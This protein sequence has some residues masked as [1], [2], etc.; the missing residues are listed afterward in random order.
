VAVDNASTD[1]SLDAVRELPVDVVA[2]D[3]NRG[4][5]YAANVG[6]RR[7]SAPYVLLLNPDARIDPQSLRRLVEALERDG[8]AA[9]AGP[10]ILGEDGSLEFSQRRFPRLRSTYARALFLHRAFPHAGWADELVR[11]EDQYE[12]AGFPQWLSGACLL[13]R[14]S[15]LQSVGGLDEGFFLYSE[16]V[17]LC[18]RL[19]K[20]GWTARF[21]P[22][23]TVVH[24][25]GE[26][27]PRTELLP[28]LAA[29]RV[30]Y[31]RKHRGPV[32]AG[33]EQA[34]VVLGEVCRAFV[35]RGGLAVRQA[36]LRSAASTLLA[37]RISA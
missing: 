1:G 25:G 7:G 37:R 24:V 30:R 3:V 20:A 13:L 29:S 22:A 33:L 6:W 15:A 34:G 26:S 19:R 5:A 21:E 8:S 36:H 11:E 10:R 4:F 31:A 28:V 2:L 17:D 12:R 14:R 32:A 27:A 16:D 9:V 35:S 23:A 18:K